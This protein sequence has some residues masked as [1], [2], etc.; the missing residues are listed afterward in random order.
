VA[1][2][3]PELAEEP[4]ALGDGSRLSMRRRAV[5]LLRDRVH[6]RLEEVARALAH[7]ALEAL[8][9]LAEDEVVR[10]GPVRERRDAHVEVAVEQ[11][12]EDALVR[13]AARGVTVEEKDDALLVGEDASRGARARS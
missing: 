10:V 9:P 12:L 6:E 8:L 13:G 7:E 3:V 2:V 5:P 1:D 4:R 11:V